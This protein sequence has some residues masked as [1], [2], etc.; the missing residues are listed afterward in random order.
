MASVFFPKIKGAGRKFRLAHQTDTSLYPCSVRL[1][2]HNAVE[3]TAWHQQTFVQK[4]MVMVLAS[5]VSG[6]DVVLNSQR[7]DFL[8][9]SHG[10]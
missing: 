1:P 2:T 3:C 6:K 7:S 8:L 5:L 9:S 4:T 10:G